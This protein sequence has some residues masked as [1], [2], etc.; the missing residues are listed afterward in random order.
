MFKCPGVRDGADF[1][2][3]LTNQPKVRMEGFHGSKI[4]VKYPLLVISFQRR[5]GVQRCTTNGDWKRIDE[6]LDMLWLLVR[7]WYLIR[8]RFD[9]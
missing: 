2:E 6:F 8:I 9:S 3:T 1:A 4:Q 5:R 7:W